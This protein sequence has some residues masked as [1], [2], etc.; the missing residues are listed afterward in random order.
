MVWA[1]A[2]CAEG[3]QVMRA[4]GIQAVGSRSARMTEGAR[5]AAAMNMLQQLADQHEE[6]LHA[7][8][9]FRDEGQATT[10]L[11]VGDL[12]PCGAVDHGWVLAVYVALY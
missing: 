12:H 11:M 9:R 5:R 10:D 7:A 8:S 3:K 4:A 6:Q 1:L 2:S